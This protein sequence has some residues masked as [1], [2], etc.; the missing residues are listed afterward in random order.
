MVFVEPT[1]VFL[2]EMIGNHNDCLAFELQSLPGVSKVT[3]SVVTLF[4]LA[5]EFSTK[6]FRHILRKNVHNVDGWVTEV[7]HTQILFSL[8]WQYQPFFH[9]KASFAS[10]GWKDC[11]CLYR[12]FR[13]AL[14]SVTLFGSGSS[15]GSGRRCTICKGILFILPWSAGL[16]FIPRINS[17][18]SNGTRRGHNSDHGGLMQVDLGAKCLRDR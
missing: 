15:I 6:L 13:I 17:V 3:I 5:S 12:V 2:D 11:L 8:W 18:G 10:D 4:S 14:A 1:H 7:K 9:D 16:G